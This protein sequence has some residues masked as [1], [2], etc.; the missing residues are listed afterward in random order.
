MLVI[1]HNSVTPP[2]EQIKQYITQA[3]NSGRFE[4]NY[5]LLTVR[6][7][8]AQLGV[9]PNTVAKAYRDLESDGIIQTRGR[10]GSFVTGT[11]EGIER[12]G[13]SAARQFV[14]NMRDLGFDADSIVRLVKKAVGR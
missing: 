8:A 10:R 5:R 1:D 7:L 4:P 13:A 11:A 12:A 2:F 14:M 9:A 6:A 3:R